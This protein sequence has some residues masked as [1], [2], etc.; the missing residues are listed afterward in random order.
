M[1]DNNIT[2]GDM[3]RNKCNNLLLFSFLYYIIKA[4]KNI[5]YFS[6]LKPKQN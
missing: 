1:E 5:T 6:I 3:Y 4:T 2:D